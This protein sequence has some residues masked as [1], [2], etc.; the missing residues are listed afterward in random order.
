MSGCLA[1]AASRQSVSDRRP[2]YANSFFPIALRRETDMTA[3][4]LAVIALLALMPTA[5][6]FFL[7][8]SRRR[9]HPENTLRE[10]LLAHAEGKI[11]AEEFESRQAALHAALLQA[12]QT[13]ANKWRHLWLL[14]ISL[15]IAAAILH[16]RQDAPKAPRLATTSA[17]APQGAEG[18]S[19]QAGGDLR[20]LVPRLSEKLA[21]DPGN[22]DGWALLGR[23]YAEMHR[24]P[25][26]E[27]A[28]AKAAGMLRPDAVLLADWA[29]AYVMAHDRKWDN[30]ALEIVKKALAADPRNLKAL[31]LAGSEA[32][33]KGNYKQATAY[34]ARMKAVAPPQSMAA[35]N[36][37]TNIA[38]ARARMTG[39]TN[40]PATANALSK[41][42]DGTVT[43]GPALQGRFAATDT[44]FVI[45][46]APQG[47]GAP[48]AV[49]RFKV[50]ELPL[51]F[52]LD[53]ADAMVASR[54]LSAFGEALLVARISKSGEALLQPG[55]IESNVVRVK[56]GAKNV[57]L[58][59]ARPP[60][61]GN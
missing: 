25:E 30:R 3:L 37:E 17:P 22:G 61:G 5:L 42:I 59:F 24:F 13:S 38:E 16:E 36:A 57:G 41:S 58:E 51:K 2:I 27:D 10:L 47:G 12:P 6:L 14:P 20:E 7:D 18:T 54:T 35:K 49:K 4:I 1:S 32:F 31:S 56:L 52:R 28:F 8:T 46:K 11:T 60:S 33:E 15:A 23:A 43:L 29:D 53:D 55:D 44:V 48:L 39:K 19:Q 9:K 45:A 40:A 26:A 21:R 34:W 50:S